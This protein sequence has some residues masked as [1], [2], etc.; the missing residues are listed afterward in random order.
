MARVLTGEEN[1]SDCALRCRTLARQTYDLADSA[2]S[3]EVIA[4]FLA[5]AAKLVAC[6]ERVERGEPSSLVPRPRPVLR[7]VGI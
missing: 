3:P 4:D 1:G 5:I 7:L 2:E 6:A